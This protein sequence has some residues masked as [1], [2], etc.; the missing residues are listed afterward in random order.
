MDNSHLVMNFPLLPKK[1]V[2]VSFTGGPLS[3]DGGVLLLSHLDR[4]L[5]LT[6]RVAAQITDWRK[7]GRVH[8]S[9]LDLVRQRVYQLACGYEDAN[10]A[11]ALRADPAFKL[12]LGRPPQSGAD[13][14]SQPSLSRLETHITDAECHKINGLLLDLFLETPRKKPKEVIV[15]FDTSEHETHGQQE[16]ALYNKHYQSRCYLP[17]FAF[18]RVPEEQEEYLVS[19]ELPDHHG[20]D[21]FALQ[22]TLEQLVNGMRKRWP[23]VTVIFRADAWF[24]APAIYEWCEAHHVAYAIAMPGNPVL[25]REAAPLVDAAKA[26]AARSDTGSACLFGR[27]WYQ[28]GSWERER[29]VVVKA[30]QTPTG[31]SLRFVVVSGILGKPK[32]QYRFY[33]GR[34]SGENRIKELKEGMRSERLSCREFESNKARLTLV[35]V[36]Y[37]LMQQLRR[38][39][40]QTGLARTQVSGLRLSLVKIAAR[41][42]ESGR[43]VVV[44]L[45]SHCPSQGVWQELAWE[46]GIRGG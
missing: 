9:L 30:E 25:Y 16:L 44:E 3:S 39:A 20:R 32:V 17:L 38:V 2:A 11:T 21:D 7:N 19:A 31:S 6:E 5:R 26:E 27:V 4:S 33:G 36:G 45:C 41:V 46:M 18:A 24:G 13:L 15:D 10:D 43:R 22:D 28:A 12:A 8:H 14:A 35:G 23:G 1:P 37:A 42:K 29:R 40:K 34:G